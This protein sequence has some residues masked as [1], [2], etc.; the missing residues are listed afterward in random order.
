MAR[1]GQNSAKTSNAPNIRND[2]IVR[3]S[4]KL[5]FC[6]ILLSLTPNKAHNKFYSCV[7]LVLKV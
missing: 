2:Q 1:W 3:I 5:F 4:I 7:Y 6:I